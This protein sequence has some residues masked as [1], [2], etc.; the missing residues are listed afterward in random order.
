MG[1]GRV[2]DSWART[3]DKRPVRYAPGNRLALNCKARYYK[4]V[5]NMPAN[6]L[7]QLLSYLYLALTNWDLK[8]WR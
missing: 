4:A 5:N 8:L 3:R 7:F 6:Y 2:G 1:G